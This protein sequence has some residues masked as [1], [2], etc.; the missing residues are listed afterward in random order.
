MKIVNKEK[1][2][3]IP[4][5]SIAT[6]L[7]VVKPKSLFSVFKNSKEKLFSKVA[8][9]V[10]KEN[11]REDDNFNK[12]VMNT[13]GQ[14]TL[15]SEKPK[16]SNISSQKNCIF[17]NYIGTLAEKNNSKADN[18]RAV[19]QQSFVE[20]LNTNVLDM[21]YSQVLK[22]YG[23]LNHKQGNLEVLL[24]DYIK[25]IK[26]PCF[27]DIS[28][29]F[30]PNSELAKSFE[31]FLKLKI[32]F[33]L[34]VLPITQ[35]DF[36]KKDILCNA[37]EAICANL[38]CFLKTIKNFCK[39]C[40]N[41]QAWECLIATINT[42]SFTMKEPDN[43][44]DT[45]NAN[46]MLVKKTI[47]E[48]IEYLDDLLMKKTLTSL[49]KKSREANMF[50][51]ISAVLENFGSFFK[52]VTEKRTKITGSEVKP[53]LNT[54]SSF[55]Y[56]EENP[57]FILQPFKIEKY[58]PEKSDNSPNFTLVLDL[59]ETLVHFTENQNNG[60]FLVR[61]FAREFLQKLSGHYE[62]IVFTAAL[63]DYADWILDRIDP[64]ENVKYRLYRN[65]T[66][67]QNDIYL[68]D[69]SKLN[70]DLSK[71]IIV[72]NNPDNFQM[73]PENG[74]CIKSWYEDPT[75]MALKYL[76]SLLVKIANSKNSD[77]RI[78]LADFKKD[79]VVSPKEV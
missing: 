18:A 58:L 28:D 77:I 2:T 37:Y 71:T 14:I 36:T 35:L 20:C 12:K 49:V 56:E 64:M 17:G 23:Y 66:T 63:K 6:N 46:N 10:N 51:F 15:N 48:Y 78:T 29:E 47:V 26:H 61:P 31:T 8:L 73:H 16:I 34:Y 3:V 70:R 42:S 57:Y 7:T 43:I 45:V 65:H 67:F 59:D 4:G 52:K 68:K 72:D 38:F 79:L 55:C 22:I 60:K 39:L 76:A 13:N 32:A 25:T 5:E 53:K 44:L 21:N 19:F 50:K 30:A 27:L 62:I 33:I 74:I 41:T 75:D 54:S 40:G 1:C 24:E 9:R 11:L 69:L